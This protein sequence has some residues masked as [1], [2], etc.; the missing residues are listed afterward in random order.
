METLTKNQII[1]EYLQQFDKEEWPSVIEHLLELAITT[2]NENNQKKNVLPKMYQGQTSNNLNKQKFT[3]KK[4]VNENINC[5]NSKK[6][7]LFHVSIDNII[8]DSE[9]KKNSAQFSLTNKFDKLSNQLTDID[10]KN[11]RFNVQYYN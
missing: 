1:S 4:V 9:N 11:K 8:K 6:D 2:I 3:V 5:H 10:K 7:K